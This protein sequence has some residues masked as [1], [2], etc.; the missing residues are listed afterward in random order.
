MP[1]GVTDQG[2]MAMQLDGVPINFD[3]VAH[4]DDE[5]DDDDNEEERRL[6]R[7]ISDGNL[8]EHQPV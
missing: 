4:K 6:Q 3:F 2:D 7:Q 5:D 8:E 1:N